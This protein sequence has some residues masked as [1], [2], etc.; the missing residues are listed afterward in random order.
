MNAE[1]RDCW[2]EYRLGNIPNCFVNAVA[3]I[4][5]VNVGSIRTIDIA[6]LQVI[7]IVL[8]DGR[9]NG[10][11]DAHGGEDELGE[12]HLL[13]HNGVLDGGK[14]I[15]GSGGKCATKLSDSAGAAGYKRSNVAEHW[16]Y[17][18]LVREPRCSLLLFCW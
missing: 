16:Y 17:I 6:I 7:V 9:S 8:R 3:C 13:L 2:L 15:Q 4:I 5:R 1:R 10:E 18:T 12:K 11:G 14:S